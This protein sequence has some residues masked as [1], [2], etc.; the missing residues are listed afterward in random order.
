[1]VAL[2][3]LPGMD[4]TALLFSEFSAALGPEFNVIPVSYP[5]DAPLGYAE[6]EKIARAALPTNQPFVLLGESFS[7]PIAISIAASSPPGLLGLVLC[8]SFVRSPLPLLTAFRGLVKYLPVRTVPQSV[9]GF[10]LLGR[11]S[12]PSLTARFRE[13]LSRVTPQTLKARALAVLSVDVSQKLNGVSVPVLYLRASEDRVV[14]SGSSELVVSVKPTAEVVELVAPHFLLQAIPAV[15]AEVVS[16]FVTRLSTNPRG[17]RGV[18]EIGMA[19]GRK[20]PTG[21]E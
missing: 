4:G 18:P 13:A 16:K 21:M 5:G 8:S 3:L 9:L 14:P 20:L 10:F 7:G 12:S 2:V 11:F 17:Q 15:A 19:H 6:L 1:M